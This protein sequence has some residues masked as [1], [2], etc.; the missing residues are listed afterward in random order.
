MRVLR[1]LGYQTLSAAGYAGYNTS[2][3]AHNL[4]WWDQDS[5]LDQIVPLV[6]VVVI[7]SITTIV[8]I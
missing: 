7:A 2:L 5:I 8:T 6:C 4:K 3:M 1:N